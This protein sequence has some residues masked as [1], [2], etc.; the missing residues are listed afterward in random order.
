MRPLIGLLL[1]LNPR[2]RDQVGTGQP[3]EAIQKLHL[4]IRLIKDGIDVAHVFHARHRLAILLINGSC[5]VFVITT[6]IGRHMLERTSQQCTLAG[7]RNRIQDVKR[8][9]EQVSCGNR[10]SEHTAEIARTTGHQLGTFAYKAVIVLHRREVIHAQLIIGQG[11]TTITTGPVDRIAIRQDVVKDL[12]TAIG[13]LQRDSFKMILRANAGDNAT[14][15]V[16]LRPVPVFRSHHISLRIGKVKHGSTGRS[17][18]CTRCQCKLR[19]QVRNV[20]IP[21][22]RQGHR[23]ILN[24]RIGL[25]DL[26]RYDTSQNVCFCIRSLLT[27]AGCQTQQRQDRCYSRFQIPHLLKKYVVFVFQFECVH[28]RQRFPVHSR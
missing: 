20:G 24:L 8:P 26:P 11:K 12:I 15:R 18:C 27:N 23:L 3:V 16:G 22:D 5:L 6:E 17:D 28:P 21:F 1:V 25:Q 7:I 19:G 2:Y 4:L 14:D 9:D 13:R 10:H